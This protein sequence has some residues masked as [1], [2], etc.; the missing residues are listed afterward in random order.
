[1]RKQEVNA[2]EAEVRRRQISVQLKLTLFAFLIIVLS[3]A[4]TMLGYSV[5]LVIFN[6]VGLQELVTVYPLF[7]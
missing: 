1:M 5:L 2:P 7:V 6:R 4:I 3:C